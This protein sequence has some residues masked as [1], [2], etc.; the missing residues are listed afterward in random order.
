MQYTTSRGHCGVGVRELWLGEG[1]S[2][3]YEKKKNEQKKYSPSWIEI[4]VNS[5]H[6]TCVHV[7]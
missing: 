4:Y 5:T 6:T 2:W 1:I 3:A 7:D